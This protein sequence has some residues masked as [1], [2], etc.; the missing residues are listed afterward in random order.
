MF[1]SINS[2]GQKPETT[3]KI[4]DLFLLKNGNKQKDSEF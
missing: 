4:W 1:L 3:K 2:E